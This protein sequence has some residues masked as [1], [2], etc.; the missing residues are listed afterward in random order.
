MT[1]Y[2]YELVDEDENTSSLLGGKKETKFRKKGAR[3]TANLSPIDIRGK[4]ES[5]GRNNNNK[6]LDRELTP[7]N[8]ILN[9]QV[10]IMQNAVILPIKKPILTSSLYITK[11]ITFS[12]INT[13]FTFQ[14]QIKKMIIKRKIMENLNHESS[15]SNI[16][17]LQ[18]D[19][20]DYVFLSNTYN[21]T[22]EM[23]KTLSKIFR[24]PIFEDLKEY[25]LNN[26]STNY[27]KDLSLKLKSKQH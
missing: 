27:I 21:Q 19:K 26:I 12:M 20:R 15:I 14:R 4:T 5:I 17:T 2:E 25:Q 16:S 8:T 6:M 10:S 9:T 18:P 24:K 23:N 22:N 3:S 7:T 13:I 1:I 11:N